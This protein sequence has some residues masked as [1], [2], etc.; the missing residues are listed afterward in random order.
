[1]KVTNELKGVLKKFSKY[2]ATKVKGKWYWND[3]S[4]HPAPNLKD[5]VINRLSE[6]GIIKGDTDVGYKLT[7]VG[8]S[9]LTEHNI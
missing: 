3:G 5:T 9:M 4:G 1:M 6:R 7:D 2:T 8:F